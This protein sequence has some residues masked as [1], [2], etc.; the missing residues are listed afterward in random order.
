M[1]F[2]IHWIFQ[3]HDDLH[4]VVEW[5][6]HMNQN[7]WTIWMIIP[8]KCTSHKVSI[9]SWGHMI[10]DV[11]S[12]KSW[13]SR[14]VHFFHIMSSHK[15]TCCNGTE[16]T[17]TKLPTLRGSGALGARCPPRTVRSRTAGSREPRW[18]ET[19]KLWVVLDLF[20]LKPLW[21]LLHTRIMGLW[22]LTPSKQVET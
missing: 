6:I 1:R 21:R 7:E 19:Y 8:E 14:D 16:I 15:A 3:I 22:L 2:E 12:W 17:S 4:G 10:H 5:W 13:I 18:S 20:I 9:V 11:M